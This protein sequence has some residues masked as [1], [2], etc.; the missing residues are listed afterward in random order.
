MTWDSKT[1][2]DNIMLRNDVVERA[3]V[4]IYRR[5]THD[6]RT[7]DE[8]KHRNGVGF[9]GAHAK[10]GSYYARWV[11]NGNR[12]TGNHLIKARQLI[13]HYCGQLAS[14]AAEKNQ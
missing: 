4:A 7:S 8:T 5:Q 13:L 3:I 10:L 9:S 12:L 1:I 6:E 14:I 11:I 2:R